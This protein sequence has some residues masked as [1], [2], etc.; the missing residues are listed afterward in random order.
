MK[1]LLIVSATLL[2]VRPFLE[3]L[4]GHSIDLLPSSFQLKN[5]RVDLLIPGIGMMQTAFHL[6]KRFS[7]EKYDCAI[8]AGICGSFS[9][10]LPIGSV[11]H[12]NE[13]CL[14][15]MGAEDHD[16]FLLMSELGFSD[17]DASPFQSGRFRNSL[18]IYSGFID[19]LQTANGI[20]VN[21]IH[22]NKE[23]I[24]R[25]THRFNPLTESMEGAAFLY[26][27]LM[28]KI[29]NAQIRAVSNFVEE[30]DRSRWNIHLAIQNLNQAILQIVK[31][32]DENG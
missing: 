6:G 3:H 29:P 18:P 12:I 1:K 20:T 31:E 14:S 23:S 11:I 4:A 22:G 28:N 9:E 15:E 17:T 21:T 7:T 16:S 5:C 26:A 27:C 30:R 10:S 19:A 8:N 25:V 24:A 13:D 32:L 2:E